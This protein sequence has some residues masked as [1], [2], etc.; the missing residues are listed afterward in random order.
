VGV[1]IPTG[2][3]RFRTLL[4]FPLAS[5]FL[6]LLVVSAPMGQEASFANSINGANRTPAA[7]STESSVLPI[8]G[9]LDNAKQSGS[10]EFSGPC[11]SFVNPGFP[12]FP[13][14]STVASNDG[15]TVQKL[16]NLFKNDRAMRV[17]QDSDGTIRMRE[18]GVPRDILNVRIGHISFDTGGGFNANAA[19]NLILSAPEVKLFMKSR[20]IVWPYGGNAATGLV[21][22]PPP[23]L[24]HISG[25][26]ENVTVSDALGR[27]LTTFPGIWV[28]E[29]CPPSDL[30]QRVIYFEFYRRQD[31]SMQ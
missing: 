27:I 4:P 3:E 12:E 11:N 24:P 15:S 18:R 28:Y 29:N 2:L 1:H 14:V 23:T 30:R 20:R 26:M 9:I 31:R 22:A 10:L 6:I 13:R 25:Q 5:L 16:R 8:L 17:K 21:G 19:V 7:V